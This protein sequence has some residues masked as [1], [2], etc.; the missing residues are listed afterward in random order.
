MK[1]IISSKATVSKRAKI[2]K[3]VTICDYA[4]VNDNVVVGDGCYVGKNVI[5]GE[6]LA[7][8]YTSK[9]YRNPSTRIS[10][11]SLLRSGTIVY[12]GCVLGEGFQSGHGA[13]IREYSV[14]GKNCSF[15]IYSQADGYVKI[16]NGC[17]FHNNVF[18]ASYTIIKDNVHFYPY[19]LTL[20]SPHPP[21]KNCRKGPTIGKGT[22]I[23]AKAILMP[24]VRLGENVVVGANSVVTRNVSQGKLVYGSPAG[25]VSSAKDIRCRKNTRRYPYL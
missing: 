5:L 24:H 20:D 18:I 2:G 22:I 12:A 16:G 3:R 23:G 9:N 6:P 10:K 1:T 19:S 14:F 17:R 7:A 8:F 21:C 13:V 11:G 15:G 25:V 4:V